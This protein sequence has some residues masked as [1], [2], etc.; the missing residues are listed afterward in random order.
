M[1]RLLIKLH[2]NYIK[3]FRIGYL[4]N[5]SGDSFSKAKMLTFGYWFGYAAN[6]IPFWLECVATTLKSHVKRSSGYAF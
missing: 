2:K 6:H 5:Q 1:T 3:V 4:R